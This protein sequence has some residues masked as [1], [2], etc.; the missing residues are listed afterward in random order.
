M[1]KR[2][3]GYI[4]SPLCFAERDIISSFMTF[5]NIAMELCLTIPSRDLV[6]VFSHLL[7]PV[8][9]TSILYL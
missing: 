5:I 3:R 6:I 8:L 4:V 9:C 7:K 1:H 2:S